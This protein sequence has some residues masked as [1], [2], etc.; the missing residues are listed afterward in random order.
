MGTRHQGMGTGRGPQL[1]IHL[2]GTRRPTGGGG[3]R[4][5][6]LRPPLRN[7]SP[8]QRPSA[9]P[10]FARSTPAS[11]KWALSTSERL[12]QGIL[13]PAPARPPARLASPVSVP[14]LIRIF[15]SPALRS[16][17]SVGPRR[18]AR[19]SP[20]PS[21]SSRLPASPRSSPRCT[22]PCSR[23]AGAPD[24][25]VSQSLRGSAPSSQRVLAPIGLHSLCRR[26]WRRR[27]RHRK[28]PPVPPEAWAAP[29][30]SHF[31]KF[32]PTSE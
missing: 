2:L 27:Q 22:P 16:P 4:G 31:E 18:P 17:R 9:S 30:G 15:F 6:S 14:S 28:V 1:E 7:P 19:A 8:P 12:D 13:E 32:P 10:R 23:A 5:G 21:L 26:R 25:A 20:R 29:P 11:P 3:A 24:S